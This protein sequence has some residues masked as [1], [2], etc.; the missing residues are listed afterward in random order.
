VKKL[1]LIGIVA[2]LL[3]T[4]LT[5]GIGSVAAQ[6][7]EQDS[8]VSKPLGFYE[9]LE[10]YGVEK[11]VEIPREMWPAIPPP[12]STF[13]FG[14]REPGER[15]GYYR[16]GIQT[17]S[18]TE[19]WYGFRM[20]INGG[21]IENS[22]PD[23]NKVRL[24]P[25]VCLKSSSDYIAVVLEATDD[26][27]LLEFWTYWNNDPVDKMQLEGWVDIDS[28]YEYS[29]FIDGDNDFSILYRTLPSGNWVTVRLGTMNSR[30][31]YVQAFLEHYIPSGS[32]GE[33]G[34]SYWDDFVLYESDGS[35]EWWDHQPDDFDDYPVEEDHSEG[36]DSWHLE[37][38]SEY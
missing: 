28:D 21:A 34:N 30:T 33:H 38:W 7:L 32:P 11:A 35:G 22:N 14:N 25:H 15:S 3:I 31:S 8:E 24:T 1:H 23:T 29:L 18:V 4:L 36:A 13:Y 19:T 6:D 26:E 5:W 20:A 37:T 17:Y 10:K 27:D 9:S 12:T 2:L 16:A